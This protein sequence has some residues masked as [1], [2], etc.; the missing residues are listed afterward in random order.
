MPSTENQS[1]KP[2]VEERINSLI[3][4]MT[5]EEKI[6]QMTQVENKSISPE[7]VKNFFIGSVLSGGGGYPSINS[8]M[9]WAE[10]V[11]IYQKNA[12]ETRMAIPLIYGVDAVH[13]H[14]NMHGQSFFPIM[15]VLEH[16]ATQTLF[17]RLEE[18]QLKRWLQLVFF[19]TLLRR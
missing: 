17:M 7:D 18:Q 4:K 3:K 2:Q 11:D 15:S 19:G 6:G 12:M 9:A 5:I 14:S 8:P 10:M 1:Q 16:P 13:G